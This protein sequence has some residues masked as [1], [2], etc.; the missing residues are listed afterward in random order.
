MAKIHAK[1]MHA[2]KNLLGLTAACITAAVTIPV[3]ASPAAAESVGAS[4][5]IRGAKGRGSWEFVDANSIKNVNLTV[6]DT[7]A[8]GH[9]VTIQ[10]TT[11][12]RNL[13]SH[14]WKRHHV[15]DGKGASHT[16]TTSATDSR[17][18]KYVYIEVNLMDGDESL[19]MCNDRSITNPY[20]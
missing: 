3:A 12:D 9:H 17:G 13:K 20:I 16:W 11:V 19:E 1:R 14:S 10:L 15:Y 7:A 4:C 8:D 2:R 5:S 18:L 6:T